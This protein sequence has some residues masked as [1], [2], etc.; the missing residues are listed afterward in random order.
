MVP[1]AKTRDGVTILR[2]RYIGDDPERLAQLRDE[3]VSADV[4]QLI[5]DARISADLSQ[6]ELA[7]LIGTTQSVISRLEDSDYGGRSLT[8]L[9]RI[10]RALGKKLAVTMTDGARAGKRETFVGFDSAW[11]DRVPGAISWATFV[12]GRFEAFGPPELVHFDDVARIVE[13][14]HADADYVL[15]ALDQPTLVPNRVGMRPVERVAASLISKLGG[16]VQP[17]NRRKKTSQK[18]TSLFGSDA[19]VWR[20]LDRLDVS[21]NPPAARTA[22]DGLH[23]IEVFPALALP[24]LDAGI[25]KRERAASY[26]PKN[27]KSFSLDDWRLVATAVQHHAERLSLAPLSEWAGR[28]A[29]LDSPKKHDQDRLDA[30]ICLVIAL[31]WR[32]TS[33]D[34]M[35]VIG[36]RRGYMVTPISP[37]G[38][39][40]L[41]RAAV[42]H[43]VPMDAEWSEDAHHRTTDSGPREDTGHG[44]TGVEPKARLVGRMEYRCPI[45]GCTKVFRGSRGGWD[46]HVASPRI[47]PDWH[48]DVIDRRV[49]KERFKAE[50][51]DW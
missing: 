24:A 2:D 39:T 16:G 15:V 3:R 11:G 36:D 33:R 44:T 28:C 37:E 45:G 17:A 4:A 50:Y 30:A 22:T 35:A 27:T 1:R 21:Q 51:P 32:R 38:R 25:L 18:K 47:H 12:D 41:Q 42:N 29:T 5:H 10:A 49:R 6:K 34:Q 19:P 8:M 9:E 40:I 14:R 23:L 7:G 13:E 26:N 46:A 31:L 48:P 43:K 20:F